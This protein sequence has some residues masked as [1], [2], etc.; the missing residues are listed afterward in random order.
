MRALSVVIGVMSGGALA[1]ADPAS[2]EQLAAAARALADHGDFAGAAMQFR[3]AYSAD[4]RPELMCNVGVAYYKA[5]DFPH[6]SRYLDQ[7]VA[8]GAA[9]D[10][11]FIATV[12]QVAAAVDSKLRAD[13][14]TPIDLVV[15]P[16]TAATVVEHGDGADEPLVGSRRAWVPYGHY[17]LTIH[18]EGF[19][20]QV[21]EG[22][23]ADHAA[24]T[25]RARLAPTPI[26]PRRDP[27]PVVHPHPDPASRQVP[28]RSHAGAIVM[29]TLAGA[30]GIAALGCY[31]MARSRAGDAGTST[32]RADYVRLVDSTR[33][34][35]H[36]SWVGAG[37]GGLAAIAA[38]YLWYRSPAEPKLTV[39]A[40][41]DGATVTF[42][43]TW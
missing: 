32:S 10:A 19:V 4:P 27:D 20:D 30:T 24:I 25:A 23:A 38:G 21:V 37:V 15:E 7:C 3:A 13:D 40:T 41:G 34:W 22:D 43:R 42:S 11:S 26:A 12:R 18:A 17:K 29:T 35:Q 39:M 31:A 2:A 5:K 8:S 16:A 28:E 1:Y 6:A 36:A 33:A 14:F 9:L